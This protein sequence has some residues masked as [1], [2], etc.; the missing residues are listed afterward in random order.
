MPVAF[1]D[2]RLRFEERI[3]SIP[4][5]WRIEAI[6]RPDN[7]RLP[8][9]YH[10]T[11]QGIRSASFL[12]PAVRRGFVLVS[13]A[14]LLPV[15]STRVTLCERKTEIL[16]KDSNGNI[17]WSKTIARIPQPDFW[18]D[19]AKATGENVRLCEKHP[20]ENILP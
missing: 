18:D 8:V 20:S 11:M 13:G 5:Q 16:S 12:T 7:H 14:A 10:F 9:D 2:A 3:P 15:T 17:D 4:Y 1:P 6:Q 19:I